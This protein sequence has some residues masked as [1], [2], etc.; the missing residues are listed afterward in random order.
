MLHGTFAKKH[1]L[2]SESVLLCKALTSSAPTASARAML[3]GA[4]S[5]LLSDNCNNSNNN[6]E[7]N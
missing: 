7:Y 4:T 3:K 2:V 6:Y 5:S 1:G